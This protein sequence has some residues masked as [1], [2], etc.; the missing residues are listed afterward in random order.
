MIYAGFWRRFAALT[1]DML[2]LF[3]PTMAIDAVVPFLGTL[4][5]SIL[6]YPV[7]ESSPLKATIGKVIMGIIVVN[8]SGEKISFKQAFI[9]YFMKTVSALILCIGYLMNLFT[10]K[11]Q[12]LHDMVAN[13][14][15]IKGKATVEDNYFDIWFDN[16]KR[17]FA[18]LSNDD[19]QVY[20]QAPEKKD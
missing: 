17:L 14:Y 16:L 5:F 20:N 10:D 7:L 9:R 6:Y 3:I 1:I 12:T 19:K 11:R 15:V 4:L 2:I 13:V 8:T 18:K